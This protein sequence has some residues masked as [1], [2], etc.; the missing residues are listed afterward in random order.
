M[1][2]QADT[3]CTSSDSDAAPLGFIGNEFSAA[4][5]YK[6][7]EHIGGGSFGEVWHPCCGH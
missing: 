1:H 6:I 5:G 3:S 7:L 2:L 4:D